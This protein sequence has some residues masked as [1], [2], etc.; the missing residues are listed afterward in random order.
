MWLP[1]SSLDACMDEGSALWY[2]LAQPPSVGLAAPWSACYSSYVPERQF[3]AP[4][5]EEDD[6]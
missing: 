4:V 1:V 2:N 5:D 3:N 6:L